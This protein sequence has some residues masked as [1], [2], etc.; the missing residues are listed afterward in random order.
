MSERCLELG[1]RHI[2]LGAR[3]TDRRAESRKSFWSALDIVLGN[4]VIVFGESQ[5]NFVT[6]FSQRGTRPIDSIK[7]MGPISADSHVAEPPTAFRDHIDPKYRDVAPHIVHHESKG[8]VFVLP[9]MPEIVPMGLIA[10]AGIDPSKRKEAGVFADLHRGGWS[11][12]DRVPA[13]EEDGLIAEVLYPTVGMLLCNHSDYDYKQVCFEAYNRWLQGFVADEPRKFFGIGQTS[14]RTPEDMVTDLKDIKQKGF[15]GVMLPGIPA[16]EDYDSR[17][18]DKVWATCVELGLPISF[19]ILT[20]SNKNPAAVNGASHRGPKINRTHH[21]YQPT[22][23]LIGLFIFSGVF[24]RYPKLK[25]V[26]V[27]SD[28]GWAPHLA[29]R[30]DFKYRVQG[31]V[32]KAPKLERQ[33]SDY[34]FENIYMTFQDDMVAFQ[35]H[36]LMNHRR[37]LWASDFPHADSTYPL[38]M[39]TISETTLDLPTDILKDIVHNNVKELYGLPL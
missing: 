33:P 29:Y 8:D 9:G 23:D 11:A 34:F 24:D 37:L 39:Q 13:M 6:P 10:C 26:C 15:V 28:A 1:L 30:M 31:P 14:A 2:S 20:S 18:Y 36:K 35:M 19:H 32:S 21:A 4:A 22:M 3:R 27:E 25:M 12:K 5:M 16:V 17:I 7:A 38:S